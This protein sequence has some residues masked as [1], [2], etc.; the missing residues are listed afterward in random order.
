M[1]LIS[2][3]RAGSEW[4]LRS[5]VGFTH[6]KSEIFSHTTEDPVQKSPFQGMKFGPKLMFLKHMQPHQCQKIHG[7]HIR[8]QAN[9]QPRAHEIMQH[10]K[11]RT[12]LYFLER[13]NMRKA[14][15]S[16]F[17]ALASNGN[18]H[19]DPADLVPTEMSYKNFMNLVTSYYLDT[20]WIKQALPYVE[21]FY[22]E[23][24][25][26][27]QQPKTLSL[28]HAKSDTIKRDTFAR[29]ELV[30]NFDQV[31]QWM[32]DINIPGDLK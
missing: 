2:H 12:D 23:D 21:M 4:F 8:E 26:A 29:R 13:R 11:T 16:G 30:T 15:I 31:I 14:M 6:A 1:I 9:V 19:D 7:C 25:L 22:F 10:L 20:L 24:L 18:F 32:D 28:D 3:P 17:C 5:L 27:G